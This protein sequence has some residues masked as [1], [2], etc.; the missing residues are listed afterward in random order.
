MN[1]RNR[2]CEVYIQ[3]VGDFIEFAFA[4]NVVN[5][6]T[7]LCPCVKCHNK[8]RFTRVE[9]RNHLITHGINRTYT[10]WLLHGERPSSI[11]IVQHPP[12]DHVE[13]EGNIGEE[14]VGDVGVEM[15][16][17]VDACYGLQDEPIVDGEVGQMGAFEEHDVPN[18]KYNEYKR[19]AT[20][21]LYPS[22]EGPD[23]TLSA[24]D[25]FALDIPEEVARPM[26]EKGWSQKFR[27][28]KTTLRKSLESEKEEAP[29]GMD[30]NHW[31]EFS[32]NENKPKKKEQKIK[33]AENRA[34]LQSSHC[35]GQAESEKSID[36]VDAW[37][38]GHQKEDGTVLSSAKPFYDQVKEANTKRESGEE[39]S[40]TTIENDELT[41]VFEKDHGGRLRGI[42]SHISKKQMVIV[43]IGKA[44]EAT[45]KKE[46]AKGDALKDE[47]L[48]SMQSQIQ[49][50]E[51]NLKNDL[52]LS[53]QN[54]FQFFM[55]GAKESSPLVMV[56]PRNDGW[57]IQDAL[58]EIV[59]RRTVPQV[60]INGNHIGG[61]DDNVEVYE[62]GELAKLVGVAARDKSDL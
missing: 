1:E 25:E 43:E 5:L 8:L 26:L 29:R 6:S 42:R 10:K 52:M 46:K 38:A 18:A 51:V 28:Y 37:F 55:N 56:T 59:G 39:G 11:L 48:S 49:T 19:L 58:G 35:L 7:I 34:Q 53:M 23:T 31:K 27:T 15:G 14:D 4:N 30:L 44:N 3:G 62:S 32:E 54:L 13:F 40:R 57:N 24:I 36:P 45:K 33:N 12:I 61:L 9:V 20:K 21:K 60:F 50:M 2:I 47:M 16:N 41:Q 17:L 22:C